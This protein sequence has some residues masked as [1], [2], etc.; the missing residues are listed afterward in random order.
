MSAQMYG[1]AYNELMQRELS[2]LMLD[3]KLRSLK[4]DLLER[5]NLKL[6]KQAKV[7]PDD[8]AIFTILADIAFQKGDYDRAS[9][10]IG[11]ALS[12]NGKAMAN[13]VSAKI[14]FRKGNIS[15]AFD[16]MSKVLEAM[17]ESPVVF[18]DFQFLYNCKQY[19][20][21]TAKKIT[22]DC[23]FLI[24]ST[25]IAYD[26][27]EVEVPVSPFEN[28]PTI[29]EGNSDFSDYNTDSDA[30]ED[31]ANRS[32][33][34]VDDDLAELSK[35]DTSSVPKKEKPIKENAEIKEEKTQIAA[36]T[37]KKETKSSKESDEFDFD[38]DGL[39]FDEPEQKEVLKP[40]EEEI[41][42]KE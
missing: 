30:E 13:Y 37:D 34:E 11:T 33:V 23:N 3:S 12:N 27:D 9:M 32:D 25:P 29:A 18:N 26:N 2:G 28:D 21:A 7:S 38:D 31:Y 16:Q 17:P 35:I 22:K 41:E 36:K 5:T 24:R 1:E 15:Q 20:V 42:I 6:Q 19:G 40:K 39:D 14:L 8:A 10:Y 4:I